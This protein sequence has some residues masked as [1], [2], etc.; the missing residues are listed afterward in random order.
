MA[1]SYPPNALTTCA[2]KVG[3]S[4]NEAQ[5]IESCTNGYDGSGLLARHGERT[6]GLSPKL[7]FVPWITFNGVFQESDFKQSLSDLKT[8]MCRKLRSAGQTPEACTFENR[9]ERK[10]RDELMF[11]NW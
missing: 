7:Y 11:F 8:V 10:V 2:M 3:I 4:N 9:G 6:N 5:S 1:S